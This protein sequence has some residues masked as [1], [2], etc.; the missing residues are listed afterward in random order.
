M[1]GEAPAPA[2]AATVESQLRARQVALLYQ[3]TPL[4]ALAGNGFVA[5]VVVLLLQSGVPA[6]WVAAWAAGLVASSLWRALESRRFFVDPH[7]HERTRAW[8]RRYLI[9]MFLYCAGWSVMVPAFG[10]AVDSRGLAM[11]VAGHAGVAALGVFTTFSVRTASA[12]FLATVLTPLGLSFALD[13][14]LTGWGA[15]A[16]TL[17]YGVVLGFEAWRA[18]DRQTETSRLQLQLAETAAQAARAQARAEHADQ[19]K[20]RFLAT[21]SHEVRT[22]L[23]GILGLGELLHRDARQPEQQEQLALLL[24]SARHLHRMIGDLLDLSRME[25]DRLPLQPAAFDPAEALHEVAELTRPQ[26]AERGC[27][28]V[29]KSAP[30][31]APALQGDA[32]RVRQ[33][34]YNLLGNAIKYGAPGPVELGWQLQ[35]ARLRFE[36]ADR[37][38]GIPEAWA[39]RVFEPFERIPGDT[40]GAGLGLA[41]SRRLAR[42]MGGELTHHARPGG[43]TCFVLELPAAPATAAPGGNDLALPHLSGRVLVADDNDVNALVARAMLERLGLQVAV[44]A[45]GHAALQQ[46]QAESFDAVLMDVQM[47]LLDGR[48]ATRRWR[49]QERSRL[50]AG[51]A[52]ATAAVAVRRLPVIGLT[53][54]VGAA[55]RQACLD[56]GM[57]AVLAKPCAMAELAA[58]LQSRLPA[59]GTPHADRTMGA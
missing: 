27:T 3:L 31:P 24:Q 50:P 43:G 11:L 7:R 17:I 54:N 4:P 37:G 56:A 48:E 16:S 20:S 19:A 53:A 46:L 15:A 39:E 5:V 12:G 32:A 40:Q 34:L 22:P 26:A 55:E 29:L 38:P 36:V 58:A 44:V 41:V 59:A 47:P 52:T 45:D 6:P 49:A 8:Q 23:N 28:L 25:V 21:V 13:G 10:D 1:P 30:M 9:N 18:H 2:G 33:V 14:G 57:D 35:G 51:A 42:A